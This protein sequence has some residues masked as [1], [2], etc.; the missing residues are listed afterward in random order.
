MIFGCSPPIEPLVASE[1][2]NTFGCVYQSLI[3]ILSPST[4]PRLKGE[5]GSTHNTPVFFPA[6]T[7]ILINASVNVLL[8]APGGPV[9]PMIF[10]DEEGSDCNSVS[11]P[12]YSFS[13]N[14]MLLASA[15]TSPW[16]I[17]SSNCCHMVTNV[18]C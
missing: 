5:E 6:A 7:S 16:L 11:Y 10:V 13:T 9:I 4:A 15:F 2:I 18:R 14:E 8:P 3:R 17:C 1:R 12:A